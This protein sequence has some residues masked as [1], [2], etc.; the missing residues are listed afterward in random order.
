M[1][2]NQNSNQGK[3]IRRTIVAIRR[4]N[5][6]FCGPPAG[7][8]SPEIAKYRQVIARLSPANRSQNSKKRSQN[9]KNKAQNSTK[10]RRKHLS[11]N[12]ANYRRFI[13]GPA[14][15]QNSTCDRRIA[16]HIDR[17]AAPDRRIAQGLFGGLASL[18]GQLFS[19]THSIQLRKKHNTLA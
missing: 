7:H 4:S 1:F 3:A 8:L 17:I 10:D 14:L 18:F 9:S 15:A 6:L 16:K 13:A 11:P 2:V 12:I 5:L 19:V